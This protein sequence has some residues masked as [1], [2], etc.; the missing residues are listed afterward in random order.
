MFWY[1]RLPAAARSRSRHV[2][3]CSSTACAH[4]GRRRQSQHDAT[5]TPAQ[6]ITTYSLQGQPG[7]NASLQEL[8]HVPESAVKRK[9]LG[10]LSCTRTTALLHRHTHRTQTTHS[11]PASLTAKAHFLQPHA[12]VV[13]KQRQFLSCNLTRARTTQQPHSLTDLTKHITRARGCMP[14]GHAPGATA[15]CSRSSLRA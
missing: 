14:H 1:W 12:R 15:S 3:S 6:S 8:Y 10:C 5:G 7:G 2:S 11:A 13:Q 4:T 9:V